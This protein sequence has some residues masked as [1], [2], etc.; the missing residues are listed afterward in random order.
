MTA[1]AESTRV[2]VAG[3]GDARATSAL[4]QRPAGEP[5]RNPAFRHNVFRHNVSWSPSI[6]DRYAVVLRTLSPRQR[7]GSSRRSP[8]GFTTAGGRRGRSWL[9]T[10]RPNSGS[11]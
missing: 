11:P 9:R 2:P 7:Q 4:K 5:G 10:W 6:A 1:A 3:D 8:S